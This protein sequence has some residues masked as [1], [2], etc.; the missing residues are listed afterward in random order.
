LHNATILISEFATQ[1]FSTSGRRYHF[2]G[3]IALADD[4]LVSGWDGVVIDTTDYNRGYYWF[5]TPIKSVNSFTFTF[6]LSTPITKYI[7]IPIVTAPVYFI[8]GR[9]TLFFLPYNPAY[10][11]TNIYYFTKF[12]T[13]TPIPDALIIDQVNRKSGYTLGHY[14]ASPSALRV[15]ASLN[16]SQL[17]NL[18]QYLPYT[19]QVWDGV[20]PS[21][22]TD[23]VL[24]NTQYTMMY[25][26]PVRIRTAAPH[27]ITTGTTVFITDF[28][29]RTATGPTLYGTVSFENAVNDVAGHSVTVIDANTFSIPLDGTEISYRAV[30]YHLY[31]VVVNDYTQH[32]YL[33]SATLANITI[34]P[35]M[36]LEVI[37]MKE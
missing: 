36:Q 23:G 24:L 29:A 20:T 27:G 35:V 25:S 7:V 4:I 22:V 32:L 26:N 14:P 9:E 21:L 28:L 31:T 34:N 13:S 6:T 8:P 1:S 33:T 15:A 19:D 18:H 10:Y 37:T 17:T 12:T 3:D 5:H 16:T 30:M 2:S 11:T